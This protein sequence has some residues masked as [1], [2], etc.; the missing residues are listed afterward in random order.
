MPSAVQAAIKEVNKLASAGETSA[1]LN[2]SA[3]KLF[4]LSEIEVFGRTTLS[5]TGEGSQYAY[6]L[7]GNSKVKNFSG[8]ANGWWERSPS[9]GYSTAFCT[10]NSGGDANHSTASG[11]GGVAFGFCF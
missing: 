3:D 1:T 2:T 9:G 6:Y 11:A 8:S 7:A 10:V 5:K 4:L